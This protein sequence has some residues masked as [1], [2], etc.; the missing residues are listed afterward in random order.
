MKAEAYHPPFPRCAQGP[1][2][3]EAKGPITM[4][5]GAIIEGDEFSEDR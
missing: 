2:Q 4:G 3:N 5:G 1:A